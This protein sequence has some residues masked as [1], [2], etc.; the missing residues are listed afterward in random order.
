MIANRPFPWEPHYPDG[1][2]WDAPIRQTTLPVLLDEAVARY[3]DRTAIS[4]R[5][6]RLTFADLARRLAGD[7][8]R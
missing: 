6:I 3:G 8:P 7:H 4:F 1:V 2:V 5:A